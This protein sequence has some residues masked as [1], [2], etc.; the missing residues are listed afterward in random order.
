MNQQESTDNSQPRSYITAEQLKRTHTKKGKVR[1]RWTMKVEFND[2]NF[3]TYR[4]DSLLEL[5]TK[6]GYKVTELEA[7]VL[8]FVKVKGHLNSATIFDNTYSNAH[9]TIMDY[10]G[11]KVMLNKLPR[12]SSGKSYV[13]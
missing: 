12:M 2:G 1:S 8:K 10:A 13:L 5:F 6:K 11:G 4:S 7:V 9:S 3:F